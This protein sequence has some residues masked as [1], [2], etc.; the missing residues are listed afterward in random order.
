[1]PRR[2]EHH[3]HFRGTA[4]L[5]PGCVWSPERNAAADHGSNERAGLKPDADTPTTDPA[6]D[7]ADAAT[8]DTNA[9][10]THTNAATADA[11]AATHS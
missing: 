9:A 2:L 5:R 8:T 6:A 1:L 7:N 10:T 3:K 11:Y 4:V